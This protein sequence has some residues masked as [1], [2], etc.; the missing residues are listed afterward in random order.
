MKHKD[1]IN[2]NIFY[3]IPHLHNLMSVGYKR[4]PYENFKQNSEFNQHVQFNTELTA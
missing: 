3:F 2:F 1:K 4:V